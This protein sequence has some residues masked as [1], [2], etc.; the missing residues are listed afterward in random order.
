M[1]S[2]WW[3]TTMPMTAAAAPAT[4]SGNPSGE[5]PSRRRANCISAT[6][7]RTS[8]IAITMKTRNNRSR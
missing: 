6:A 3:K 2:V 1:L 8:A 5:D 4:S 7:R